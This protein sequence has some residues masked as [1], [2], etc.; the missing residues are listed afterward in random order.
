MTNFFKRQSVVYSILGLILLTHVSVLAKLIYF[1][2]PELFIYPYLTNQGLKPYSQILDQ[3]FPGLM[4]LPI[5][6]DNLGM[7]TPEVARIWSIS[8]VLIIH[9]MLFLVSREILK[10]KT[11]SLLVNLL[12]LIWQPFF[13][14]W[15]LWIDN[16]LPLLLLPAF[17]SLYRVGQG[18][19]DNLWFFFSGLFLG[20]GIIFKQV[21]IPLAGLTALYITWKKRNLRTLLIFLFGL[22]IPPG[23]MLT[24]F[25]I[26]GVFGDFWYWAVVFNLTTFAQFGRGAGP[27][28]AHFSRI[29]LVFGLPFLVIRKI[30]LAEVQI[31]LIFLIGTLIGLSTRFDFVHFQPALPF[32][33]MA[34]VYGLGQ[35][36][37][38]QR[39]GIIGVYGLTL[40]WWLITFYKGHL[41]DRVISFDSDTQNLASK[42]RGYTNPG[43]KIFVYGAA[44]HLYQMSSTLPAGDVF[45]F[46]F[47]WFLKVSEERILDGITRDKPAL[48][49]SDRTVIIEGQK[50]TEFAKLLDQY[51]VKNYHIIDKVGSTSIMRRKAP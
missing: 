16:F 35:L 32:A 13:E 48:V 17:Y 38:L 44:P 50:I 30:K 21:L 37:D 14:G 39:L 19:R 42:I 46:Q 12:Y 29:L 8:I 6:L 3:H 31:L 51:I 49:V 41:G 9:I 23:L 4:F 20:L 43:E 1:P 24:F 33:L 26:I 7:Q 2:Y 18:N 40:V 28:L 22:L 45:V 15:V 10:S 27:T 36:R 47:P 34:T 25:G 5:N 11:K